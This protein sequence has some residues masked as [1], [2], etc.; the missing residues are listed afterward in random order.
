MTEYRCRE[1]GLNMVC[2]GKGNKHRINVTRIGALKIH[3]RVVNPDDGSSDYWQRQQAARQPSQLRKEKCD[4]RKGAEDIRHEITA[5]G[6]R[7]SPGPVSKG[8]LQQQ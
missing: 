1:V 7:A 6:R 2:L 5:A 3:A 8:R 4:R